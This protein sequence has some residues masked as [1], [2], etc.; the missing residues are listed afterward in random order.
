MSKLPSNYIL[1]S[2]YEL[3]IRESAQLKTVWELDAIEIQKKDAQESK[4]QD[5]GEE[6]FRSKTSRLPNFDA[7]HGRNETGAVDKNRKGM[8]VVV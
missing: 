8:S 3:G 4:I 6:E 2:L 7:R 1:E 5:K